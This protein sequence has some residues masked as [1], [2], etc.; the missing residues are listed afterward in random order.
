MASLIP[1]GGNDVV[2]TPSYLVDTCL[3]FLLRSSN[4]F[5][6][7]KI[8][9]DP[10]SGDGAFSNKLKEIGK[11]VL[12]CEIS[13][14]TDFFEFNQRADFILTNPPWSLCRQFLKHSMTL[15]DNIAFL[16]TVNHILGL[17][18]RLRD[19]K[20][21]GFWITD[22]LLLDTPKEFPQSGFQLGLCV[23]S[24]TDSLKT[25]FH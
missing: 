24:K 16:I 9:L 10:A 15:T 14:G 17:K 19:L 20:Q 6:E 25:T 7:A 5:K 13:K 23:I 2:Y 3:A 18:A 8:V 12:E 11:Q 22:V 1:K 4:A 21:Q